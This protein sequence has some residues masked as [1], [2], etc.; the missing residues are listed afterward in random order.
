MRVIKPGRIREYAAQHPSAE[1]SLWRWLKLVKQ[2]RWRS[3]PEVRQTFSH[4]DSVRV[5]SG[6]TVV[7]FNIAG[8]DYRLI[9]AVHYAGHEKPGKVFVGELLPHSEYSKGHWKQKH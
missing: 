9:C 4:A 7:V 3:W 5:N 8:K 6:R 2:A 1:R